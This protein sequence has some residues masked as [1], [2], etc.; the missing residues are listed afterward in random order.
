M[1]R[2][3]ELLFTVAFCLYSTSLALE[4]YTGNLPN[5]FDCEALIGALFQLSRMPG[6]DEPKEYGR[7]MDSDIFSEKIPKLI[8]LYGPE[9]Y[10]CG[11]L[12]DVDDAD[13]YAVDTFRIADVAAVA[14]TIFAYCLVARAKLGRYVHRVPIAAGSASEL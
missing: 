4:C 3:R 5:F 10:N 11:I 13:Y 8:H 1:L 14:N 9:E 6:Q 7:T 2:Y 12:L